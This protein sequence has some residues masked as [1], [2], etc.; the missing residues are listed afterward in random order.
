MVFPCVFNVAAGGSLCY[1]LSLDGNETKK[2]MF[3]EAN[4]L[5]IARESCSEVSR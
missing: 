5:E 3:L 4:I 1:E 2:E